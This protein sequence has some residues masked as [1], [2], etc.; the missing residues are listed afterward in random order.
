MPAFHPEDR[1]RATLDAQL[2]ACGWIV[3]SRDGLN[4][5]AGA[6]IAVREFGTAAGPT[7]YGLFVDKQFCGV[8]EA[9]PAG[10]TLSGYSDQ[11]ARYISEAP[12]WLGVDSTRRRFEY[13][14]SDT[15]ILFR[16]HADPE[17]RSRRVFAF[18]RPE[19]LRRRLSEPETLRA[20]LRKLPPI[21]AEGLRACQVEALEGLDRSLARDDPR[22]LVQMT[23]G[24]GKTF[25]ACT[26]SYRL[27]AHAGMRKILFLVDRRN[28]GNQTA[29]EYAAYHPPGTGRL[30]PELYGVQKLGPAGLDGNAAVVI[31]T[32]QRVYSVLTGQ[33]LAE[34][35]EEASAFERDDDAP[36]LVAYNSAVPVETFVS[37]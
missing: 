30:F 1:S 5:S 19:T 10:T 32:I 8:I 20:R 11:A 16:D 24:A 36:K 33:E 25:T 37:S 2:A 14:A 29:A 23:M 27:L 35:E 26:L 7:D 21:V 31:S 4:L 34:E 12:E 15:E 22:A 18:H 13:V 3:Q 9:K 17:P 28:L 6:G